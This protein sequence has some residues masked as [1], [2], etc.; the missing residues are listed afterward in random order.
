MS[1]LKQRQVAHRIATPL[2]AVAGIGGGLAREHGRT[3]RLDDVAADGR[4]VLLE[5]GGTSRKRSPRPDEIAEGVDAPPRLPD[6]LRPG[7]QIVGAEVAGQQ[8]LIGTEGVAR[9]DDTLRLP[10]NPLQIPAGDLPRL[11]VRQLIN[12]DDLRPERGHHARPLD[13]VAPGHDGHERISLDAADNRQPRSRV[14]AGQLDHGLS[15][16]EASIGFGIFDHLQGDAVLLREA[17][18][19]VVELGQNPAIQPFRQAG[20][21]NQRRVADRLQNRGQ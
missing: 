12:E 13:G 18:I 7:M 16:T 9:R 8:E 5:G 21:F 2:N 14:P 10:F 17:G 19:E 15:R 1:G 11:G 4:V 3:L 6:E 20:Q